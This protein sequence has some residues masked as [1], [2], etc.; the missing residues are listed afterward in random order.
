MS[1]K[2]EK[3]RKRKHTRVRT[4]SKEA[5]EN[6]LRKS[7]TEIRYKI[8]FIKGLSHKGESISSKGRYDRDFEPRVKRNSE[9]DTPYKR[10]PFRKCGKLHGGECR[11]DSNAFYSSSKPGHLMKDCLYLRGC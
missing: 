1:N 3:S 4:R 10:P 7:R 5:E 2:W 9:V 8:M 11:I 6:F